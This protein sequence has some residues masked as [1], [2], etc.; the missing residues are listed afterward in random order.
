MMLIKWDSIRRDLVTD[1]KQHD[2]I[3]KESLGFWKQ[4]AVSD[5]YR[6]VFCFV[7]DGGG[8]PQHKWGH[9]SK[10]VPGESGVSPHRLPAEA[11]VLTVRTGTCKIFVL[12]ERLQ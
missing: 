11:C 12:R 7:L 6:L 8:I 5:S 2:R 9:D 3:L 4:R 1:C 10:V